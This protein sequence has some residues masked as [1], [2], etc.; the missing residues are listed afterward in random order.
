MVS[1]PA[2]DPPKTTDDAITEI[3]PR[4]NRPPQVAHNAALTKNR[5]KFDGDC[6]YC[7]KK[8]HKERECGSKKREEANKQSQYVRQEEPQQERPKCNFKLVCN[9]CDY[10][11]HSARD[12]RYRQKGASAFRNVPLDKRNTDENRKFRKKI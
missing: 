6:L 7:G 1:I 10:T 4:N 11:G 2:V 3:T 12:C 5:P 9:S 8:G